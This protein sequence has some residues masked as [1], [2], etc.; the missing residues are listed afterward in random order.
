M[1]KIACMGLRGGFGEPFF[2]LQVAGLRGTEISGSRD[3][4]ITS[5][6]RHAARISNVGIQ[7]G[8][9]PWAPTELEFTAQSWDVCLPSQGCTSPNKRQVHTPSLAPSFPWA[10]TSGLTEKTDLFCTWQSRRASDTYWDYPALRDRSSSTQD[11][12]PFG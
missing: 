12:S 7:D 5:P 10:S 9:E 4:W 3:E 1:P 8:L 11:P 2:S 6:L